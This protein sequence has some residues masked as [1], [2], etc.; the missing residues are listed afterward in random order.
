M[1]TRIQKV[2]RRGTSNSLP[3]TWRWL[4]IVVLTWIAMRKTHSARLPSSR[5]APSTARRAAAVSSA[6]DKAA[7]CSGSRYQDRTRTAES[8]PTYLIVR[9]NAH[10]NR[11]KFLSITHTLG[12]QIVD[13]L[14]RIV[15]ENVQIETAVVQLVRLACW[16]PWE[17]FRTHLV[18]EKRNKEKSKESFKLESYHRGQ[19]VSQNFQLARHNIVSRH[20]V[21]RVSDWDNDET[22]IAY[23][24]KRIVDRIESSLRRL[25]HVQLAVVHKTRGVLTHT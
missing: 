1:L 24:L 6:S 9:K 16:N 14:R 20:P 8:A 18:N 2:R 3:T 21:L 5:V 23:L 17:N 19:S 12:V 7:A 13:E 15:S 4:L 22:T 25:R 11:N 10:R